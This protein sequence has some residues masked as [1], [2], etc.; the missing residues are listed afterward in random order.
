MRHANPDTVIKWVKKAIEIKYKRVWFLSPNSFAY[1]SPNGAKI[2]PEAVRYLLKGLRNLSPSVELYYG[3]FP[4]EVRPEFV[5]IEMMEAVRPYINN[6][7]FTIGAQSA[8]NDL[9]KK[10][11]RGHTF[12][13][14][15]NAID[16]ITSFNYGVD[17]DFI[18]GLPE[19]TKEDCNLTMDYFKDVLKSTKNIRIH[20]HTFMP[21]P[22][23]PY[24]NSPTGHLTK[25]I[26][27]IVGR[28]ESSGK[29]FGH[30]LKQSRIH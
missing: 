26:K 17:I 25:E 24:Q 20:A 1:G 9:L 27:E 21:L 23:T 13:D 19:E 5:T 8:S 14:V 15:V 2:N 7:F 22:G 12:E 11:K 28:L 16:I 18:F 6:K 3:T 29:A 10:I 4:S 30:Y